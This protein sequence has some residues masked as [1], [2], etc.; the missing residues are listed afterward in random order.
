[1]SG[2]NTG[3][4]NRCTFFE[5]FRRTLKEVTKG[6]GGSCGSGF[7]DMRM[8]EYIKNKFSH[9]GSIN[10]SALENVMD[11]FVNLIKVSYS[12]GKEAKTDHEIVIVLPNRL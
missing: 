7:L 1:M 6:H 4:D 9:H 10:E 5:T 3:I 11:S 12:Q 2:L 8:R